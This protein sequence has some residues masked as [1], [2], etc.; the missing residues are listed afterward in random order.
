M[1]EE[2]SAPLPP[3]KESIEAES[4]AALEPE[5]EPGETT[6]E[7][8]SERSFI[9]GCEER[10][11]SACLELPLYDEHEG[12]GYCVLHYPSSAKRDDFSKVFWQKL[13]SND[14]SFCGVW[15]PNYTD[16]GNREITVNA[17]FRWARFKEHAD[18]CDT[19]FLRGVDFTETVFDA[20][21]DFLET[22]F[23]IEA[24]MQ[25]T[26]FNSTV[27]FVRAR[28]FTDIT[29]AGAK[30]AQRANFT[31]AIFFNS[32]LGNSEFGNADF[33][34]TEFRASAVF[35]SAKFIVR[36]DFSSALFEQEADFGGSAFASGLF[37]HC[38]FNGP[39]DF[40]RASFFGSANFF[41]TNF[42]AV[43][44]FRETVFLRS[45]VFKEAIFKDSVAFCG[46]GEERTLGDG[47]RLERRSLGTETSL[48]FQHARFE[49]PQRILFHT[50]TLRPH[51]FV[52]VD[53]R[54]F[55][56][57]DV[58]WRHP[59]LE[60]EVDFLETKAIR[61][62]HRVL[63]ITYRQLAVNAE[64]NHRYDEA[65]SFRYWSMAV[66]RQE[67]WYSF[68]PW[69]RWK[70]WLAGRWSQLNEKQPVVF[71]RRDALVHWLYWAVS[72]YGERMLRPFLWLLGIWI[73]FA[74]LY[75]QVGFIG[76]PLSF[77]RAI[78][79]SLGT[80]SL[81]RLVTRPLTNWAHSL[82]TVESFLVSV[83]A[84]LLAL[85]IHRRFMR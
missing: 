25:S 31:G 57:N 14:L 85:A 51:W 77:V 23:H 70:Q 1:V 26:E 49:N 84:A 65:A 3:P 29:F 66:R 24:R 80:M 68:R 67:R 60:Q 55:V 69:R 73:V 47:E 64:E 63:A 41:R 18:F 48:D 28:F 83:Q 39:S 13:A 53:V 52:N 38:H 71:I 9:C 46:S 50:V 81:Q 56:F 22:E 34:S 27:N 76:E 61:W 35:E 82:V 15:F 72:G 30:F 16:L 36:G 6:S 32:Q 75:T 43:T 37:A 19:K 74:L 8:T 20:T 42:A 78:S 10:M 11:R 40:V 58:S 44:D 5:R 12:K 4:N 62:P 79:Y 7:L 59:A 17:D 33:S 2:S 21:A 45:A 54:E